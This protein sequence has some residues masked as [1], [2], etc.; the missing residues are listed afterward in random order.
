M[1]CVKKFCYHKIVFRIF[2]I[3][4]YPFIDECNISQTQS[5]LKFTSMASRSTVQY[6]MNYIIGE[7]HNVHGRNY[8]HCTLIIP[9]CILPFNRLVDLEQKMEYLKIN[10]LNSAVALT[11]VNID[12]PQGILSITNNEKFEN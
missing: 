10:L 8:F 9:L 4:P 12:F 1:N 5:K 6:I 11:F 2:V 3:K 7:L